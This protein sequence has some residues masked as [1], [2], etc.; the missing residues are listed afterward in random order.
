MPLPTSLGHLLGDPS[1]LGGPNEVDEEE[2]KGLEV[3]SR[4][5]N[6]TFMEHIEN[7]K[8]PKV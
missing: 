4:S 5:K 3:D 7:L 6:V 1:I 8:L 2:K